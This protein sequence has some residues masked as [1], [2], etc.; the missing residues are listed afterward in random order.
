VTAAPVPLD[1]DIGADDALQRI[2]RACL[3][4]LL[5]NEA[6]ALAGDAEG[7]HQMRVASR[8]L[9]AAVK[10][11][12]QLLPAGQRKQV[13]E[14]LD[15]LDEVLGPAR[16]LD[17][18]AAELLRAEGAAPEGEPAFTALTG[19]AESARRDAYGRVREMILSPR[20]TE[21]VLRL[22][23]WFEARG[24]REAPAGAAAAIGAVA[25]RLLS[26]RRALA[27]DRGKGFRRA[28]PHRRHKL[29][30]ALKELRYTGE[31]LAG[32]FPTD[33]VKRF[34]KPLKKLQDDLGYENDVRIGR[35]LVAQLAEREGDETLV[36]AGK[37][38]LRW[39]G[40]R[41]A[42]RQRKVT[43]HL[44]RLDR[45]R[46]FWKGGLPYSAA[47]SSPVGQVTPVPP[48]PQ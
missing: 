29:R 42:R 19:A 11:F 13:S 26:R 18:F 40:T 37:R 31:L 46:P 15:G 35:E 48:S 7:V 24:W 32:L 9:R 16:N 45:T 3:T 33:E 36:R 14:A 27:K 2:G 23:R 38:V 30:I 22:L 25:P 28:G 12:K 10:A 17:V 47:A 43:K 34:V 21:S 39:H 1:P 8:R 41:V 4:H 5:H 20:Y 6:A 44:R